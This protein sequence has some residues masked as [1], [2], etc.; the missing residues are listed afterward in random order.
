M[1]LIQPGFISPRGAEE[2]IAAFQQIGSLPTLASAYVQESQSRREL[3]CPALDKAGMRELHEWLGEARR[4]ALNAVR[5]FYKVSGTYYIDLTLAT[6]MR[7][8]D[9]HPLHADNVR[10]DHNG[11]WVSNHTPWREYTAMLYLN[12]SGVDYQG[13]QLCFPAL[14]Q[15]VVPRTG[16]LVGF[17]CGQ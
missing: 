7:E 9:S 14:D 13:G 10:E 8:G 15:K 11:R 6:E 12:S 2:L 17:P 16:L 5:Q 3:Y 4:R 1:L